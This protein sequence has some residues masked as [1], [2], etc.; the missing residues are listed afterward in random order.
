M[1]TQ[2][3][4]L[5]TDS[6]RWFMFARDLSEALYISETEWRCDGDEIKLAPLPLRQADHDHDEQCRHPGK[7]CFL[8]EA[9]RPSR[10]RDPVQRRPLGARSCQL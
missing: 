7:H 2:G 1:M 8:P 5:T 10:L 6:P 4:V 9:R 3:E